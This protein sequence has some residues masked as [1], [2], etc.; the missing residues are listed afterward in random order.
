[1]FR[2][3]VRAY[4]NKGDDKAEMCQKLLRVHAGDTIMPEEVAGMLR[5]SDSMKHAIHHNS[6]TRTMIEALSRGMT[7]KEIACKMNLSESAIE[8]KLQSCRKT[9]NASTNTELVYKALLTHP[10]MNP[11]EPFRFP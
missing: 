5:P 2:H 3:G 9:Y 7:V 6:D 1:M 4:I 10:S 8:K 11:Q